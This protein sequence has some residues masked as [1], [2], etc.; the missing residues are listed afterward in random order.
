VIARLSLLAA[1]VWFNVPCPVQAQVPHRGSEDFRFA[2][3]RH[4]LE[5][6]ARPTDAIFRPTDTLLVIFGDVSRLNKLFPAD[7]L[8]T[9]LR[10]GGAILIA[11]DGPVRF[12]QN[13]WS[14]RMGIQI[15]GNT[16]TANEK[17]CYRGDADLPF[18][19]P[20]P[21]VNR[22]GQSPFQV[23]FSVD[24]SGVNAVATERPSAMS[25]DDGRGYLV[26]R[27]ARYP[28]GSTLARGQVPLDPR[29]D[30]FAVNLEPQFGNAAGRMIVMADHGVFFNGMMGFVKD[31]TAEQGYA[32]D[33][34]NW[35]FANRT[36]EWLQGGSPEPRT[37]CLFIEHGE[38]ID[39][40]A[41]ETGGVKPPMPK[42][43]PADA[44]ANAL[45]NSAANPIIDAAQKQDFFNRTLEGWLGFPLLVRIFF[46]IVTI[47]F[48]SA[49]LR[50]LSG[51]QRKRERAAIMT[52]LLQQNLLPRG[53]VLRQ[54]TASQIEVGNLYDAARRRV[55]ERFDVLGGRPGPSD[56]MPPILTANDLPDGP[57]LHQT[58][59]WLWLLGYGET[60]IAI[61]PTDWDRTNMLLERATARAARGDWSF[62]LEM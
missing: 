3:F 32:F 49:G 18:V 2:L 61:P 23:F 51:G 34:N 10:N 29:L 45:L 38:V 17:N 48:I 56:K 44:L 35:A 43:P 7:S 9:F 6:L 24:P 54:R 12:G 57:L 47:V 21:G 50:W 5:P 1:L 62:G 37:K 39:Q 11:T 4:Q 52:P 53:G 14:E 59:R 41:S 55:R 60:P 25:V 8:P 26:K 36:I 58:V 22:N 27:L 13:D 40:F 15:T 46:I 31:E 30:N 42:L 19:L 16:V 20:R 28:A 33:N